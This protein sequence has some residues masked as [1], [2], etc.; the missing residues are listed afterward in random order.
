MPLHTPYPS[1]FSF[2]RAVCREF[3]KRKR[4]DLET[5][6]RERDLEETA[7]RAAETGF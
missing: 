4:E 2:R 7:G 6:E 5:A 3:E 1:L